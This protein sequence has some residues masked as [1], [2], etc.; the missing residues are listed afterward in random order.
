MST[1]LWHLLASLWV[2]YQRKKVVPLLWKHLL[3]VRSQISFVQSNQP[4]Y[5]VEVCLKS[6]SCYFYVSSNKQM[7]LFLWLKWLFLKLGYINYTGWSYLSVKSR[8]KLADKKKVHR[9][10]PII[11]YTQITYTH[12]ITNILFKLNHW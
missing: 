12:L 4:I 3:D 2:K 6:V 8:V 5:K 7:I 1:Y 10:R 9:H 11:G